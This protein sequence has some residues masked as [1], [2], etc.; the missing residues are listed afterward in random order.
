MDLRICN[1]V[2]YFYFAYN[3]V[4]FFKYTFLLLYI[5]EFYIS[6]VHAIIQT[7]KI[8]CTCMIIIFDKNKWHNYR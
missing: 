2:E 8:I 6:N 5:L 1:M 3:S 7:L 4:A